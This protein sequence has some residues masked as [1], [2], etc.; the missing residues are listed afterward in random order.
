MS[1]GSEYDDEY[2][3][4]RNFKDNKRLKSFELKKIHGQI[5]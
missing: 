1:K 5:Y 4:R 2:Y 3:S